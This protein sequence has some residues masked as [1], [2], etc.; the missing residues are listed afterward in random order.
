MPDEV[1]KAHDIFLS[2]SHENRT[3][4]KMLYER[5]HQRRVRAV[6]DEQFLGVATYLAKALS[7]P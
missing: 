4:V 1:V 5:L 3:W 7:K 6:L 2:Y